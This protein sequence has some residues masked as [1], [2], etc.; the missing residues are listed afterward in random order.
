MVVPAGAGTGSNA[1]VVTNA[2]GSSISSPLFTVLAVYDG[3]TLDA[4]TAAVPPTASLNDGSWHYL[5]AG[6][7]QVVA[8]YNY[9]GASLGNLAVDVLRADPAQPVRQD[10]RQHHYLG[11]NWHLR[12]SG[13]RFDGRTVGLRLY[14]LNSEQARLQV[15]DPTATLAN[16]KATQ[17]SGPN[18]DC[19]L[20]NNVASAEHRTLA[21]PASSP[22]G[23][24][25][26]RAELDVTD[27]FSEFYLTGSDTPLPVE[28]LSFTAEQ[29][30]T[31]VALAWATASEKN[32]DRFEV[33]RSRDGHAFE[34]IGQVAAVGSS[35]SIQSYGFEDSQAPKTASSQGLIY[36][37]LRQVDR[38]GT[39]SYS[40]VR[41][42][43]VGAGLVGSQP[44]LALYP[45]P[46]TGAATLTGARPG[47]VVAMYDALGRQVLAAKADASGT[48]ALTMPDG[49]PAGVY[50]VRVGTKTLRL[51][52]A[53]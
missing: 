22:A 25:Y 4:C 52:V 1:V 17:Y 5:L 31:T 45:N 27:H 48:A 30:G 46:T 20:A 37:R 50:V 10:P 35:S 24:V 41:T 42:V 13:G 44:T 39:F 9:T 11:R 15:A 19:Q 2:T 7:G 29:R 12:A 28:L 32:S 33:E 14:G 43:K 21:A 34:R 18:E 53:H 3:G 16:L 23:T 40:P 26:F 47:A 49:L 38:D 36:Y 51:T 8:A 6:N